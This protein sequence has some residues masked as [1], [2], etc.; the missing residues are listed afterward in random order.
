[1]RVSGGDVFCVRLLRPGKILQRFPS[2]VV[3]RRDLVGKGVASMGENRD[4]KYDQEKLPDLVRAR[5]F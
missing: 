2:G 4:N 3:Q 5:I 1:V